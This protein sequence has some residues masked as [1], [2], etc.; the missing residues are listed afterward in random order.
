MD[1]TPPVIRLRDTIQTARL[2]NASDIHLDV[3]HQPVLRIDGELEA[4]GGMALSRD[5]L[6]EI[7]ES[8]TD[9][10]ERNA[11]KRDRE[12][13]TTC[14]DAEFGEMRVHIYR[15]MRGPAIAIRLLQHHIPTLEALGL[16]EA[17]AT[18]AERDRG[19]VIVAG[20]TGSG[21]STTLAALVALINARSAR[22]IVTIEDPI[23]YRHESRSSLITQR[24]IGRDTPSLSA[25][26]HGVLRADPDVIVVGE[27]R[28][29]DAIR[30]ALIA[31]E[32]GHLVL[33]TIHTGDAPQ[34]IDR[35]IDVFSGELAGQVRAQLAQVL[36][37]VVCQHLV[38][39]ADGS[40]RC[41]VVEI[42][43]GTDAV[44]NLIRD[45]KVHQLKN[46]MAT[47]RR[48]G[49]QTLEQHVAVLIAER[50]IDPAEALRLA[51]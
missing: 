46:V 6:E 32:T 31:A 30:G 21:K 22:R 3:E 17:V 18:L 43:F 12:L 1:R 15:G 7:V 44:R 50:R 42:L 4:I 14:S 39:R 38:S 11:W 48:F 13:T 9:D 26:L 51:L 27:I 19:L 34:T 40:G 37:A 28:D 36:V 47:G 45:A 2:R 33:T 10:S 41:A 16:P 29:P 8:F 5:E 35:V 24:E 25:A 20:P 49:M 23:E